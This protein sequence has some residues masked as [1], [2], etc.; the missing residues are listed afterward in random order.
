MRTGSYAI[1]VVVVLL[2]MLGC[3]SCAPAPET[4][5]APTKRAPQVGERMSEP[6]VEKGKVLDVIVVPPQHLTITSSEPETVFT[7]FDS[8]S[9]FKTQ[10]V[11]KTEVKNV[12][13]YRQVVFSCEHGLVFSVTRA[14]DTPEALLEKGMEVE[15][16]Y[17]EAIRTVDGID[18]PVSGPRKFDYISARPLP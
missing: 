5:N 1:G 7:P 12:P 13:A 17:R 18:K 8:N 15:I 2:L 10:Q 14:V 4:G 3:C 11:V 16:T 9:S 6:M